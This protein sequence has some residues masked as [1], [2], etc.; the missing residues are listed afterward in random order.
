MFACISMF[1]FPNDMDLQCRKLSHLWGRYSKVMQTKDIKTIVN[2]LEFLPKKGGTSTYLD[3]PA[4]SLW[5]LRFSTFWITCASTTRTGSEQ[6]SDLE[7]SHEIWRFIARKSSTHQMLA[8]FSRHSWLPEG[9][10]NM[11]CDFVALT[12]ALS[13]PECCM[14]RWLALGLG[15][16]ILNPTTKIKFIEIGRAWAPISDW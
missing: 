15:Q 5:T 13:H 6:L 16:S 9:I 14:R 2:P 8:G 4:P 1:I 7:K 11:T 12:V 3:H 10:V